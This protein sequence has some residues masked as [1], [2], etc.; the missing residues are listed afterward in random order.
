MSVFRSKRFD[1][2][3]KAQRTNERKLK[4]CLQKFSQELHNY[5]YNYSYSYNYNCL[6][7][8]RE[9]CQNEFW[10]KIVSDVCSRKL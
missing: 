5:N 1:L 7:Q 9:I 6:S 2:G 8:A 10:V 4:F 3:G